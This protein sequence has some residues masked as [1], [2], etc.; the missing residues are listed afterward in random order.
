MLIHPKSDPAKCPCGTERSETRCTLC[1]H[2]HAWGEACVFSS[3]PKSLLEVTPKVD[4]L[5]PR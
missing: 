3:E 5:K 4:E 1:F 2:R